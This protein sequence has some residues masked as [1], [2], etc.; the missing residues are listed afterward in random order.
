MILAVSAIPVIVTL[1]VPPL[2]L[3]LDPAAILVTMPVKSAPLTAG[4]V[5]SRNALDQP[6]YQPDENPVH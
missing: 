3:I 1:P 2:I 5:L 6:P 4:N